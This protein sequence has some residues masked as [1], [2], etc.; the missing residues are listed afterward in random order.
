MAKLN[1]SDFNPDDIKIVEAATPKK[2]LNIADFH[3][4]EVK[5]ISS[6]FDEPQQP[7]Q[8]ES[9]LRGAVQG[10]SL[11][12]SDEAAG[13]L[14]YF[15]NAVSQLAKSGMLTDS[16][17]LEDAY[18]Q[19]RNSERQANDMAQQANPLTYGGTQIAGGL[20][21]P[22]GSFNAAKGAI[23][24]GAQALGSSNEDDFSG[25]A[26]DTGAGAVLGGA[27]GA[28][29]PYVSAGISKLGGLASDALEGVGSVLQKGAGDLANRATNSQFGREALDQGLVKLGDSAESI[30]NRVSSR[31]DSQDVMDA[32][33]KI[34]KAPLSARSENGAVLQ[35]LSSGVNERAAK[36]AERGFFSD[37]EK[38]AMAGSVMGGPQ[39]IASV[40]GG[41]VGRNLLNTRGP[42]TG[43]VALDQIGNL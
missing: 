10:A 27:A 16:K 18:T 39:A 38:M 5:T 12:F 11:G 15:K 37:P 42:A 40:A 32:G 26:K 2:K 1:I 8:L 24:G 28:A 30:A 19:S 9:G 6:P 43:A 13:G 20:A 41:I 3:P 14:G 25:L 7:S 22:I 29:S 34:F 36:E 35:G 33:D 23:L 17:A 31:I 21:L 4:D